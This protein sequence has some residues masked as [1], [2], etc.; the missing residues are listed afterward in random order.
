MQS[1]RMSA[2][3]VVRKI[4]L[5]VVQKSSRRNFIMCYT[6]SMNNISPGTVSVSLSV[7]IGF[8]GGGFCVPELFPGV[9]VFEPGVVVLG[10]FLGMLI[11]LYADLTLNGA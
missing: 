10:A 9:V 6:Y 4:K 8:A 3:V 5:Q 2:F 11:D 1:V 7:K